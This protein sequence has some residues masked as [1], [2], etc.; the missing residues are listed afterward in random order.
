MNP[1]AHTKKHNKMTKFKDKENFLKQKGKET[2]VE[3]VKSISNR[4]ELLL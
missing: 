1:E 3:V 2:E 4:V